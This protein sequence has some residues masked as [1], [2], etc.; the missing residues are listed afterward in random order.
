MAI[1]PSHVTLDDTAIQN[2]WEGVSLTLSVNEVPID[3]TGWAVYSRW[4]NQVD[5]VAVEQTTAVS[6]PATG[7]IRLLPL[8]FPS[9]GHWHGVLR[10]TNTVGVA[11]T[12][13]TFDIQVRDTALSHE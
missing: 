7:T 12:Y 5:Q 9:S 1:T 11:E 8:V 2:T 6:Y 3:L 13:L 4:Y 10:L